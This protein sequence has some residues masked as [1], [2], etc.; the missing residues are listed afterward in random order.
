V[1]G[2]FFLR[3]K[4]LEYVLSVYTISENAVAVWVRWGAVGK[5]MLGKRANHG[6]SPGQSFAGTEQAAEKG[7]SSNE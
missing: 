7:L 1:K 3:K 2:G 4:P 6:F 5:S